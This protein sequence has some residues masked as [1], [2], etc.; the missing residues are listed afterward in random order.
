MYSQKSIEV[1]A[2]RVDQMH[3]MCH[4]IRLALFDIISI[5][6]GCMV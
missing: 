1:F 2:N 5:F 6:H 3:R 4:W